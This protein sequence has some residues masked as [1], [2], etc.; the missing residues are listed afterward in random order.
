MFPKQDDPKGVPENWT[1]DEMK[2][3]LN[4]VSSTTCTW[5]IGRLTVVIARSDGGLYS[6]TRR[7]YRQDQSELARAKSL[8]RFL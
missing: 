3:W 7:A 4:A 5:N 1:E 6:N 8:R 2:R